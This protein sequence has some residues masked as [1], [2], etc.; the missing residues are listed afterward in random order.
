MNGFK[1]IRTDILQMTMDE[2]AEKL[3]VTK[4]SIY[5]WESWK[6][7]VP[8]RRLKQLSEI[9]GIP[10]NYFLKQEISERDKLELNRFK[11]QKELKD[12][13][14]EAK[15]QSYD[16]LLMKIDCNNV[17]LNIIDTL[18]KINRVIHYNLPYFGKAKNI[19]LDD[20]VK[21]MKRK[22]EAF[23]RFAEILYG[24]ENQYFIF[25]MLRVM[26]LFFDSNTK[27][28]YYLSDITEITGDQLEGESLSV[29]KIYSILCEERSV[30]I[31]REKEKIERGKEMIKKFED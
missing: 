10:E 5:L 20:K 16:E 21:S 24:N 22:I 18:D 2:L 29:Q 13:K 14:N 30:I 1:Y 6:K 15:E 3:G 11:L 27:R 12:A 9:S 4:Q 25:E 17:E 26:E 8:S 19:S 23:N 31:Q 28:K 7:D